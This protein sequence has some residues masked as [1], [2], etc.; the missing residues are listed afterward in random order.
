MKGKKPRRRRGS[1]MMPEG[2]NAKAATTAPG[3]ATGATAPAAAA[4]KPR[5]RRGSHMMPEGAK[6]SAASAA[7]APTS[8]SA[9]P[10]APTSTAAA[11]TTE[12][13]TTT[14]KMKGKKPRRRRGSH[15]MPE[16]AKGGGAA[17]P[18][19]TPAA[20]PA[21]ATATTTTTT[22]S[23]AATAKTTATTAKMKGSK[24]RR[25]RGSHM[26]PEGAK[27]GARAT[28]AAG[29]AA[30]TSATA[31]ATA[32]PYALVS[33]SSAREKPAAT[34][35]AASAKPRRRRG[36]DCMPRGGRTPR[37]A[38]S[39]ASPSPAG[40]AAGDGEGDAM[41]TDERPRAVSRKT[42][43][44]PPP[45][46]EAS[47][48]GQDAALAAWAAADNS[49]GGG[50]EVSGGH[51]AALAAWAAADNSAGGGA[52]ASGGGQDAAA[53]PVSRKTRYVPPP[54]QDDGVDDASVDSSRRA[55]AD[56]SADGPP[57]RRGRE[58][59]PSDDFR[60]RTASTASD[61][62]ARGRMGELSV[63]ASSHPSPA[64][65]SR[66]P[67][68]GGSARRTD[69]RGDPTPPGN[70]GSP[71]PRVRARRRGSV[72]KTLVGTEPKNLDGDRAS[73]RPPAQYAGA[74]A[75]DASE[76][77][78]RLAVDASETTRMSEAT[79]EADDGD[80]L[81]HL[82]QRR[83]SDDWKAEGG[84]S[85]SLSNNRD[86]RP[87]LKQMSSAMSDANSSRQ[88]SRKKRDIGRKAIRAVAADLDYVHR[89]VLKS[90]DTRELIHAAVEPNLLFRA[91]SPEELVDL[92]DAFE[93]QYVPKGSVVIREG[94]EG[95]HFYVMERG[96]VD[97]FERDVH[98][99]SLYSGV[100]FGEIALLYSCPRTATVMAKY[101]CKLWAIDRRAFRGITARHKKRRLELKVDFLK[102]VKIHDKV[103]GEILK[104]S[105]IGSMALAVK[106]EKFGEGNTIV[107]QG[108]R[109]DVF[110]MIEEGTVDVYIK[111]K[112]SRPIVTLKQGTFFGEKA[113]LS[114]EEGVRTATCVASSDV[115]CMLL[116]RE[117]FVLM[118]GNLQDLLDRTYVARDE[119][120]RD[121]QE[122]MRLKDSHQ[123]QRFNMDDYDIKRT[124]GVG[125]FGFV[126][127][128]KWKFAPKDSADS[129]YAL[130]C[131]S[132]QKI[133]ELKQ[134]EKIK[135]E[136]DIMKSLVHPFI[137]R[138]YNV[139]EDERGK[140]FLMEALCGGELCELLYNE[141]QFPEGWSAFYSASVLA[142]FAHMHERKIAYRDLKPENL[143]LDTA[144]YVKIVDFG[145]AKIISNG[146]TYTFCGTPDYLAPEVILN[147]GYDWAV[148]YWGLG[149]LI[150]EMT[151]GVAPFYAES[152]MET[153]EKVL[154]GHVHIPAHFS[155]TAASLI[156]KLLHT[157][158]AKRLGRTVGGAQTVMCHRWYNGFDWDALMEYRLPVPFVPEYRDPDDTS[159]QMEEEETEGFATAFF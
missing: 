57:A 24:P 136:E 47:E 41:E 46:A 110:Y 137:A 49:A 2:T 18:A 72:V 26:M 101:D 56:A 109:G 138:C 55:S 153:Y 102:K 96:G 133:E 69:G 150:Y 91:C 107:R 85:P 139:M 103:L 119:A 121:E 59:P 127:L 98:K 62:S 38:A 34:G 114:S 131:V 11:T 35:A 80:R 118:L 99:C 88:G 95:D 82:P 134:Q 74:N 123:T 143:V 152:P 27:A 132:K 9:A 142:A 141:T 144:G 155:I 115:K 158:Q 43:Y 130:K 31:A 100:A 4:A 50:A 20:A 14:V 10:A 93:P 28:A 92:V 112:G 64:E 156:K 21:A 22:T 71:V 77:S 75:I 53:A 106:E 29:T 81:A 40:D 120:L 33:S 37:T 111:D 86:K 8:T 116:M 147:E 1:H 16:G 6:T 78:S 7:A 135:R 39:Y 61:A 30:G 140:Y 94:D 122:A 97:I 66:E 54:P 12:T 87:M 44:V 5:R 58:A 79:A 104:P 90:D 70:G 113:L 89:V 45:Q 25:R 124:L 148:D 13:T 76:A 157:S 126:K 125:A 63:G 73:S 151:A 149:V 23:T 145:L 83:S 51:D 48:G 128:V 32:E 108:E 60:P 42:K 17:T 36:S 105:E 68:S 52:E 65:A 117:D 19:A 129:L 67:S 154:S 3:T 146:Q 84:S 15:M 159:Y